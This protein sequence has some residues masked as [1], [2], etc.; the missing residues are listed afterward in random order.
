[1]NILRNTAHVVQIPFFVSRIL[2]ST[3]I[4]IFKHVLLMNS[5]LVYFICGLK[6]SR[7]LEIM[8]CFI[9][10]S[11][12]IYN[13]VLETLKERDIISLLCA[14]GILLAAGII[15]WPLMDVIV[16]SFSLAVVFIPIQ[17]KV[18]HRIREGYAA[19]LI[20]ISVAAGLIFMVWFAVNT[21][22]ANLDYIRTLLYQMAEGLTNIDLLSFIS[23]KFTDVTAITPIGDVLTPSFISRLF[24]SIL[25]WLT[26]GL[27]NFLAA[28]PSFVIKGFLF[29]LMLFLFL[30]SGDKIIKEI[31]SLFSSSTLTSLDRITKTTTDTMYS[32]YIVNVQVAIITFFLSIPFFI[33]L[34]YDHVLFWATLCGI[35]QL[36][37]F[38]APQ[39]LTLFLIIY[40][41]LLGDIRGTILTI[42]IG[43]PL[44][45]G[46]ADFYIR[47]KLMGRKMAIHPA[48]MMVGI[49]GGMMIMGVLGIIIG[50]LIV[51]LVVSAYDIII[52]PT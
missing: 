6:K 3:H 19:F 31:R 24:E 47:P 4:E 43:Y 36:I 18:S 26:G 14:G 45:S 33:L 8:H 11:S 21:I 27:G 32:V 49:F 13:H 7:E 39:L 29:F 46:L 44:I 22:I 23:E 30:L 16:L 51:A 37:P 12:H 20:C 40:T 17:R 34:G 42:C 15:F 35:F 41:L 2:I 50:P 48:L 1:M 28:S 10:H 25:S 5:A 52:H 9:T 38:F